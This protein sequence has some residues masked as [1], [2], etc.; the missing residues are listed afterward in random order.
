VVSA[1]DLSLRLLV[2]Q[3]ELRRAVIQL[4]NEF[5]RE[6]DRREFSPVAPERRPVTP[7]PDPLVAFAIRR[8][9]L[10]ANRITSA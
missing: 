7:E 2:P 1:E 10:I 9:A 6:F 5:F 3:A 8:N 4:H